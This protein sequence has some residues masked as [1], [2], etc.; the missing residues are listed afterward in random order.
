MHGTRAEEKKKQTK[1]ETQPAFQLLKELGA[2]LWNIYTKRKFLSWEQ[3]NI[4]S[5]LSP[6]V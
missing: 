5:C 2:V 6:A 1:G 3:S 4:P